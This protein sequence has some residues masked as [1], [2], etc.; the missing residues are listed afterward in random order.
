MAFRRFLRRL[1][2]VLMAAGLAWMVWAFA[3]WAWPHTTP[4]P[5]AT[6]S[7]APS[8]AEGKGRIIPT[9]GEAAMD[10]TLA[11]CVLVQNLAVASCLLVLGGGCVAIGLGRA[12][13][14]VL[15]NEQKS[16]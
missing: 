6:S 2:A 13:D 1:G 16:A 11:R 14:T 4:R 7:E 15:A 8:A 5:T 12:K 9:M 10:E 3:Q